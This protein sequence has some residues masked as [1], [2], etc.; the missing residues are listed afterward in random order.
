[1][2]SVVKDWRFREGI[3]HR[4]HRGHRV[5]ERA[6]GDG[7]DQGVEAELTGVIIG[8]AVEVHRGLGPGLLESAC[9]ACLAHELQKRG[10]DVLR[11]VPVPVRYDG[12]EIE[13]GFR[14]DLVVDG[15][16]LV[17][18][19]AVQSIAPVHEAQLMTYLRLAGL[20][21]GLLIDFN[22]PVLIEGVKRRVI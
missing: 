5:K 22:V 18:L 3:Q 21:V 1:M 20:R 4:G 16:V 13:C 12:V 8:A 11:Q 6:R 15:R 19:K 2:I 17:E 9:E 10:M 7:M 14:A